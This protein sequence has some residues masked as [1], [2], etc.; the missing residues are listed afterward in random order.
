MATGYADSN[1]DQ[2]ARAEYEWPAVRGLLP[3]VSGKR[4]LDAGCGSGYYSAWLAERGAEVVG[5]DASEE[6]VAEAADRYG[7]VAEFRVAD[8]RE[9]LDAAADDVFADESFDL[10]VSQ[11]ALEHVEDWTTPMS[12]FARVL[13]PGGRLV[14][15]CDHPFTTYFVIE[16]EEPEIGSA[17]AT[18]ADYYEVERYNRVWGGGRGTDGDRIEIPCFRRSLRGVVGPMFEAGFVVEN[19][20]EPR[21]P[22]TDGPLAYFQDHTPRFLVVRARK[23]EGR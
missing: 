23:A 7:D 21:P 22:E 19:L 14:I 8:L 20:R 10:V 11:L 5:I 13:N 17:D 18:E 12:E 1:P 15:S 2:Q 3:G 16:H 6:M 9:P 4:V